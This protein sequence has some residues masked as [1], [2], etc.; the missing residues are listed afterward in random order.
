MSKKETGK[1]GGKTKRPASRK[2]KVPIGDAVLG[3]PDR[4]WRL[5]VGP[6]ETVFAAE[7]APLCQMVIQNLGPAIVEIHCTESETTILMPGKL[8]VMLAYGRITIENV[9]EKWAIVEMEFM[10]RC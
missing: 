9:E 10:P 3:N 8:S 1:G 7:S 2:K 4:K 5:S 6:M